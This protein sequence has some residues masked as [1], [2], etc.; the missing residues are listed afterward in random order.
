MILHELY[1]SK[2]G[3]IHADIVLVHGLMGGYIKTWQAEDNTVWPRDLLPPALHERAGLGIR[4]LSFEYGGSI[5]GTSSQAGI[6]DTA[7][8]L[9]QCLY[10]KREDQ[11]DKSRPIIFVGHSLGGVIIK[12]AIRIAHNVYRFKPIKR[13]IIGVIFFATIHSGDR[14]QYTSF[15]HDVLECHSQT[16]RIGGRELRRNP[17]KSMYKEIQDTPEVFE[18]ISKDFRPLF[19]KLGLQSFHETRETKLLRRVVVDKTQGWLGAEGD[20][21]LNIQKDHLNIC[22][23]EKDPAQGTGFHLVNTRIRKMIEN[24]PAQRGLRKDDVDALNSLCPE[25]LCQS[26]MTNKPAIGTGDW[27]FDRPQFQEWRDK[28]IG[29][30]VLWITGEPGCGKSYIAKNVVDKLREGYGPRKIDKLREESMS[31]I[32]VFLSEPRLTNIDLRH[33]MIKILQQGLEIAPRLSLQEQ[34]SHNIGIEN[35][36]TTVRD[37]VLASRL[38]WDEKSNPAENNLHGLLSST[39]R[40]VLAE[41]SPE[42]IDTRLLPLWKSEN[43]PSNITLDGLREVWPKVMTDALRKRSITVVVDGFDKMDRQDQKEF[44]NILTEFQEQ[45]SKTGTFRIL[46]FSNNSAELELDFKKSEFIQ[47]AI[48]KEK[49]TGSDIKESVKQRIEIIGKIHKY[50]PDT[51]RKIEEGVPKAADGIFLRADLMLGSLK[52][53]YYDNNALNELFKASPQSTPLQSTAVLY[54]QIL[55]N[56]WA[57][58]S[59]RRS[60]RHVLMWIIF[61][62]E[63]LSPAELGIARALAKGR[64][65]TSGSINYDQVCDL[66]GDDTELWV[67]R[68]LGHLVKLRDNRFELIH[69]SLMK[70]LTTKS[71]ELNEDYGDTVLPH[72]GE[73]YMDP[74]AS[75][76]LLGNLCAT[77]LARPCFDQPV[78]IRSGCT[79]WFDWQAAV[80][81]RMKEHPFLQYAALNWSEHLELARDPAVPGSGC[82]IMAADREREKKLLK[83]AHTLGSWMEVRCYF[84]DW[85]E[86]K[87]NWKLCP[88][89]EYNR[90]YAPK[91]SAAKE[92]RQPSLTQ[93]GKTALGTTDSIQSIQQIEKPISPPEQLISQS[94]QPT[95]AQRSTPRAELTETELPETELPAPITERANPPAEWANPLTGRANPLAERPNPLAEQPKPLTESLTSQKE[96]P[97]FQTARTEPPKRR[98]H[99]LVR[100]AQSVVNVLRLDTDSEEPTSR[101]R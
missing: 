93:D 80:K 46:F 59:T 91:Q 6:D 31:V 28:E 38:Q 54:D 1:V 92:A 42:L 76:A 48:E 33:L 41:I 75:H 20:D 40:Q 14:Q 16:V 23:F 18:L 78:S 98:P 97:A 29:M 57:D 52:R 49:D 61:Q 4:V 90:T 26:M 95:P 89:S 43:K 72:H 10:N 88:A 15:L 13:P 86:E 65:D 8:S 87:D 68:F 25:T 100:S 67:N 11:R 77:Y 9:L 96:R 27:I 70:Y 35:L 19:R 34:S 45:F 73:S 56:V 53:T 55:G 47:Y 63:C 36:L 12:R 7:Q 74:R 82:R 64:D 85:H 79:T 58:T 30:P 17:S 5:M 32:C 94:E 44:L 39:I 66:R 69:P 51:K 24:S 81:E 101:N 84:H 37:R 62:R 21:A 22:K 2:A 3:D 50:S 83:D 60:A 71:E 99:W